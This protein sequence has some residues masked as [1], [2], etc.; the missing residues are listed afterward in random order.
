MEELKQRIFSYYLQWATRA[1]PIS[2]AVASVLGV[3]RPPART[4]DRRQVRVAAVQMELSLIADPAEYARKVAGLARQAV[5]E[6]AE[7]VCFPEDAATHLVGMLPGIDKLARAGSVEAALGEMGMEVKVADI[8]RFLGPA[9]R[10]TYLATFA[11]V[12][13]ALGVYIAGGSVVLPEDDGQVRNRQYLFAPDG[14]VVSSQAKMHLLPMEAGWGLSPGNEIVIYDAP[15]GRLGLPVCMDATYF[16]T[17]RILTLLGAEIIIN[18]SADPDDYNFWRKLRGIWPRVQESPA[19]GI[20]PC[21]V[22]DFMGMKLT[23]KS[24][25]VAPL[26]LSPHGDGILAQVESYDREGMAVAT[27]DLEA[28]REYRQKVQ[29]EASFNLDLYRRYFPAVYDLPERGGRV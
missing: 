12:A 8:F 24:A 20:N 25:I 28:L 9:M 7:L 23:G 4:Y 22:G 21:M 13:S 19:Y 2:R 1:G 17:Y 5:S 14:R 27:L 6:G 26:A 3:A 15:F 18:P 11:K 10:R 29:V 16:E